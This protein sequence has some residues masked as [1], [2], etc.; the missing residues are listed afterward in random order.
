MHSDCSRE[1]RATRAH[2]RH[3][4]RGPCERGG[5]ER[6]SSCRLAAGMA[7]GLEQV[8]FVGGH[9][10][11]G[12]TC[13]HHCRWLAGQAGCRPGW[14]HAGR[15]AGHACCPCTRSMHAQAGT[16]PSTGMRFTCLGHQGCH[17][18]H[19]QSKASQWL[20]CGVQLCASTITMSAC[21]GI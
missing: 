15:P 2:R 14:V 8:M 19:L 4:H 17:R 12:P 7:E 20:V 10:P 21:A 6:S 3:P 18:H 13:L 5:K 16:A 1:C 11:G 9:C